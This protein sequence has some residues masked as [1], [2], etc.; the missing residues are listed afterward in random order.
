MITY[1][2]W[3][4]HLRLGNW[5][6]QYT[7]IISILKDSGN[8][9]VVPDYFLWDY[10]KIPPTINNETTED[11]IFHFR[12]LNYTHEE[13]TFL[14]N[15]FNENKEKI[16]NINL[17]P[18][19]QSEKWFIENIDFIKSHL[20]IKDEEIEK[21]K[22]K[23]KEF[24]TKPTIGIGIRRGDFVDHGCF[25][26]IPEDWYVKALKLEFPNYIDYN[27]IIF[28]DDIEWCKNYY[29]ENGFLFVEPNNTHLHTDN[30]KYYRNNPMEQFILGILCDNF[31]GGSST[32]T[33]WQ[34]WY[35]KNFNN[36]KV[37]HCGEN[38]R[39]ECLEKFY[40]PDYYPE[41]WTLIK[42]NI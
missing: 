15:F 10:L 9:I 27:V 12:Q 3:G 25:Y 23:Y 38:L 17:S 29:K 14:K 31:I 28:S 21:V 34:M 41:T 26:Q 5:L 20:E 16:V 19:L 39:S 24:F 1:K 37:I 6:F 32:F 40:N 18:S 35:V 4:K 42:P 13:K 30:F 33:W 8:N 7:G 22:S 36:G 2:D 11:E